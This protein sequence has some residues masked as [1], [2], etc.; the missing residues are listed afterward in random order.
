MIIYLQG[1]KNNKMGQPYRGVRG[2]AY[3]C[4]AQAVGKITLNDTK[5]GGYP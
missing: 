1:R 5:R 3:P 4:G 2:I